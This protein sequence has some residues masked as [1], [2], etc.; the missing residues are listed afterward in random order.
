MKYCVSLDKMLAGEL[1]SKGN[2][3]VA[4]IEYLIMAREALRR[5]AQSCAYAVSALSGEEGGLVERP[6]RL[7]LRDGLTLSSGN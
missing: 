7:D 5:S 1:V 3:E 2:I 6:C 4:I